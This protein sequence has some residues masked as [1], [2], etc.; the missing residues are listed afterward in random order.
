MA[1]ESI[2][3]RK[4]KERGKN[5]FNELKPDELIRMSEN[6]LT[7]LSYGN[8]SN[9]DKWDLVQESVLDGLIAFCKARVRNIEY[10]VRCMDF[11]RQQQAMLNGGDNVI[12]SPIWENMLGCY[13][14]YSSVLG[15]LEAYKASGKAVD[16]QGNFIG[17]NDRTCMINIISLCANNKNLISPNRFL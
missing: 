11:Y 4:R 10:P 8:L 14:F 5:W 17:Y 16:A 6:I 2:F 13:R 3:T 9:N 7:D 1:R 15:Y 12:Y